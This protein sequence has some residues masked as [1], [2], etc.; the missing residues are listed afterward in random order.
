[1]L[2]RLPNVL[3]VAVSSLRVNVL[4]TLLAMLGILIGVGA[5]IVMVALGMGARELIGDRIRSMGSNLI[6]V[7]PGATKQGGAHMGAGTCHTLTVRDCDAI[8]NLC[9]TVRAASPVWGQLTQ[10]VHGNRNWRVQVSGVTGDYFLARDWQV[11]AG[12]LFSLQE[13]RAGSKVCVIGNTVAEKL[14]GDADPIGKDVRIQNVPFQVIGVLET[15][16]KSAG[17]DDQDDA[18]FVPIA[19]AYSRLFGTPFQDEVKYIVIQ[20]ESEDVISR[21][22][23][24][25]T[26]L[27]AKRHRI[28]PGAENDFTVK[29]LTDLMRASED[30][31]RILT[32]LLSS[33]ASISLLV[34]GIGVMNITLISVTERTKEIG[35]RMAVG[36]KTL[37]ILV[38]FLVEACALTMLGGAMGIVLGIGAAYIFAQATNWPVLVS[39]GAVGL[40]FSVSAVIGVFSGFYPAYR[41]SRLNPIDALRCE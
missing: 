37:D 33:I 27:L 28:A 30:S 8:R 38:Q 9:P 17:G 23:E 35:I 13:E 39:P 22:V 32:I 6:Y 26:E 1:M 31:L 20:A 2:S 15:R 11:G 12:R 7:T 24:D 41:A 21:T 18:V 10:V 19:A 4:R 29:S 14:M 34:G 3:N 40:A 16:G 36:A 5:V 25:V